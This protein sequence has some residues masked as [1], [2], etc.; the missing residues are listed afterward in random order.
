MR[1][2]SFLRTFLANP[3]QPTTTTM[4]TW[5]VLTFACSMTFFV[6]CF[7]FQR[8]GPRGFPRARRSR[9]RTLR[10]GGKEGAGTCRRTRI[11]LIGTTRRKGEERRANCGLGAAA[12]RPD[13]GRNTGVVFETPLDWF[14]FARGILAVFGA[15]RATA[16]GEVST[17]AAV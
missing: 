11:E 13:I 9:R 8:A 10:G 2:L 5:P 6:S 7:F 3:P 15:C 12:A 14:A 1:E 4:T 16:N 17:A